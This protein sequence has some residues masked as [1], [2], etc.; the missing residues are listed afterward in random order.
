M[1]PLL[2]II[3]LALPDLSTDVLMPS[4]ITFVRSFI[5]P[6]AKYVSTDVHCWADAVAARI[7]A[8]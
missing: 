7:G 6:K 4:A 1:F 3:R 8:G 5:P 2:G